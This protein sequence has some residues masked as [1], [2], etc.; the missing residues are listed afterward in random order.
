MRS[1]AAVLL[2]RP[3]EVAME[4]R[5]K[6]LAGPWTTSADGSYAHDLVIDPELGPGGPLHQQLPR[7]EFPPLPGGR[8]R[9]FPIC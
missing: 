8:Y 4:A 5:S 2:S 9:D 6:K 1:L 3:K 7:A